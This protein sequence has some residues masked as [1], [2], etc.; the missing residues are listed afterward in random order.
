MSK[1][2]QLEW[3]LARVNFN[4]LHLTLFCS[5]YQSLCRYLN[6]ISSVLTI[7]LVRNDAIVILYHLLIVT[8]TGTR[9]SVKGKIY[10]TSTQLLR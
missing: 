8:L 6:K 9:A 5:R 1:M 10:F 4:C 2:M 3:L 7:P